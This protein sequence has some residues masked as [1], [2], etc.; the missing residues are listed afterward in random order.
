MNMKIMFFNDNPEEEVYMKIVLFNDNF[1]KEVYINIISNIL[2][3]ILFVK[4]TTNPLYEVIKTSQKIEV[5]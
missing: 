1:E 4:S 2:F 3:T 5:T